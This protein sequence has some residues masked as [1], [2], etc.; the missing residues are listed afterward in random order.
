MTR[1]TLRR[2]LLLLGLMISLV[3]LVA[4]CPKKQPVVIED[5]EPTP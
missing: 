3:A 5:A 2:R 4:G 1:A